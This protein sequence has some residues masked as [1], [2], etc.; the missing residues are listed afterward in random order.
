MH[1]STPI[2]SPKPWILS[3]SS[4]H[5]SE[6]TTGLVDH[7]LHSWPTST[8][9]GHFPAVRPTFS[10]LINTFSY[11]PLLPEQSLTCLGPSFG[12]SLLHLRPSH[13]SWL[14]H[15]S[16]DCCSTLYLEIYPYPH[17]A[18]GFDHGSAGNNLQGYPLQIYLRISMIL[19][20]RHIWEC[21]YSECT[22]RAFQPSSRTP[23]SPTISGSFDTPSTSL[24]L[25]SLSKLQ[26]PR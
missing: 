11:S 18:Y 9:P 26:A 5:M 20:Y 10:H 22:S 7:L 17:M 13:I 19:Q 23:L 24:F 6:S 21:S 3:P 4:Y 15:C 8:W 1:P 2:R 16:Q 25:I 14:S 12:T